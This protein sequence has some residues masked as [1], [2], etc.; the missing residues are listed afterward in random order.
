VPWITDPL[1]KTA[2]VWLA[3]INARDRPG[4]PAGEDTQPTMGRSG[5]APGDQGVT[6]A[7]DSHAGLRLSK[8]TAWQLR[9]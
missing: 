7:V 9:R 2:R 4:D 1:V 3:M 5:V 8:W 6:G